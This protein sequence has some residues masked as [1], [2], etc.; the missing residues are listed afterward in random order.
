MAL[1]TP[2]MVEMRAR[3]RKEQKASTAT[4]QIWKKLTPKQRRAAGMKELNY[5]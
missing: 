5:H 3:L 4:L 2:E 1:S